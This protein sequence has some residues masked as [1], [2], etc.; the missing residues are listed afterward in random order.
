VLEGD[1]RAL[2]GEVAH[3]GF[4]REALA[5]GSEA[6]DGRAELRF[7]AQRGA[8]AGH[9]RLNGLT[10]GAECDDHAFAGGED[11]VELLARSVQDAVDHAIGGIGV[12]MEKDEGFGVHFASDVHALLPGRMAPALARGGKLRGSELRVVD[13]DV[14]VC[15]EFAEVFVQGGIAGLVVGGVDDDAGGSLDAEAEATLRMVEPA[16][17]YLVFADLESVAAA[18]LAELSARAHG[19]EVHG[20]IGQG[21]LRFEDLAQGVAAK[22]LRA[23]AVKLEFVILDV[24][25]SEEGQTLDVVPVIV[26]DEDVGFGGPDGIIGA[27]AVSQ[28]AKASAAIKNEL[29]AI[30]GKEIQTRRVSAKA[31]GDRV[32]GR[33]RAANAPE[34]QFGDGSAHFCW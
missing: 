5:I 26:G 22:K 9:V 28:H 10:G 32:D 1:E 33:S 25:G 3:G 17:G 20:K 30:R 24:E 4:L 23:E 31:P 13:E 21:H 11:G 18:Q 2:Q 34:G 12:V 6:A 15:G 27:P 7:A 8:R 16:R 19:R 14:C 29:R